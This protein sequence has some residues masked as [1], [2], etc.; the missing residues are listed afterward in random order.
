MLIRKMP[1]IPSL[2]ALM[3]STRFRRAEHIH[4]CNCAYQELIDVNDYQPGYRS[5]VTR[6]KVNRRTNTVRLFN[7]L[8]DAKPRETAA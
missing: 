3:C 2:Y 1:N 6:W 5:R 8:L 7:G 4:K